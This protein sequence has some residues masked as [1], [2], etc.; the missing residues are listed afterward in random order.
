VAVESSGKSAGNPRIY[1]LIDGTPTEGP[2]SIWAWPQVT[3]YFKVAG[4]PVQGP[5]PPH[6]NRRPDPDADPDPV[7]VPD[8]RAPEPPASH[9]PEHPQT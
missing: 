7:A 8:S 6:Q 1:E 2:S 4:Q 3:E 9:A 5:W